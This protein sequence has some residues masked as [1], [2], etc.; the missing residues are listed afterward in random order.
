MFYSVGNNNLADS[1]AKKK[2]YIF[3]YYL[4]QEKE[5]PKLFTIY[6]ASIK[7]YNRNSK[8]TCAPRL[9]NKLKKVKQKQI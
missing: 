6:K 8:N 4:L 7:N 2:P 3:P 5:K 9:T 1:N